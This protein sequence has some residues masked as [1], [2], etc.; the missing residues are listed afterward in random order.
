MQ[1]GLLS[2]EN[3]PAMIEKDQVRATSGFL[4]YFMRAFKEGLTN[5]FCSSPD[6]GFI[7]DPECATFQVSGLISGYVVAMYNKT[8]SLERCDK[9]D[10]NCSINCAEHI[11]RS[12]KNVTEGIYDISKFHVEII[13]N[14]RYEN[15]TSYFIRKS[16]PVMTVRIQMKT[17]IVEL[18]VLNFNEIEKSI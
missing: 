17:Y 1:I 16:E 13:D 5:Y 18:F 4:S 7:H 3:R 12:Y 15:F 11:L 14:A 8:L 10:A 6:A 9:E 2:K